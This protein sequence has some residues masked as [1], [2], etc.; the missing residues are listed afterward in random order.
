MA[1]NKQYNENLSQ[2][3]LTVNVKPLSCVAL[4][5]FC[6]GISKRYSILNVFISSINSH[7]CICNTAEVFDHLDAVM[8]IN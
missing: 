6:L 3:I 8:Q 2:A 4:K 5:A 7:L 1:Y